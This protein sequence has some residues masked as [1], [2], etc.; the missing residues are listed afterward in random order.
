MIVYLKCIYKAGL[1]FWKRDAHKLVQSRLRLLLVGKQVKAAS[2]KG[3]VLDTKVTMKGLSRW[4]TRLYYNIVDLSPEIPTL[5]RWSFQGG[6][7]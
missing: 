2:E 7:T 1:M 5:D 4:M 3:S 6:S